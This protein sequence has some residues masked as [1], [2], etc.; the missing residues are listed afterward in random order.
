MQESVSGDAVSRIRKLLRLATSSNEHEAA[1][2]VERAR[3]LM[4][5]HGISR[6]DLAEDVVEIADDR[7]DPVRAEIAR[8][9]AQARGCAAIVSAKGAL[10]FRGRP[11]AVADARQAY[12]RVLREA[13]AEVAAQ[14]ERSALTDCPTLWARRDW[15]ICYRSSFLF[16][17]AMEVA[18]RFPATP[19]PS[20]PVARTAPGDA[21]PQEP[22]PTPMPRDRETPAAA[23]SLV[24]TMSH[25]VYS[26]RDVL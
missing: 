18:R 22:T 15:D 23:R 3:E 6:E 1:S 5:R 21:A 11:D 14:S 20:E 4:D 24:Q 16:G 13:D 2:A 12:Q 26:V 8:A 7:V 10:A 9:A 19:Q 25:L 17:L